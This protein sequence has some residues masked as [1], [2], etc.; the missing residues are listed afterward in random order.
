MKR[1]VSLAVVAATPVVASLLAG[2]AAAR[3][4]SLGPVPQTTHTVS[5]LTGFTSPSGNI[6]C[7]I[8][9]TQVRC[10]VRQREWTPPPKPASCPEYTGWGQGLQLTVG[11][12]AGFVCAGDTALMAGDPLPYGDTIVAGS[13]EC[14]SGSSGISCWDMESGSGFTI[15]RE[16]YQLS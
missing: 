10:D 2:V 7:L 9:T 16:W 6:G 4:G 15:A 11:K 12:P 13:I 14:T 1:H 8:D 5:E 3:P